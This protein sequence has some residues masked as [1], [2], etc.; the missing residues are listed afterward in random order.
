M[1]TQKIL[2][3]ATLVPGLLI[4]TPAFANLITV[5]DFSVAQAPVSDLTLD[6]VAVTVSNAVRTLSDNLLATIPPVH[7]A[8]EVSSGYLDINNGTGED[9]EVAVTWLLKPNLFPSNVATAAFYF[10][11]I[12][13]DNNPSYINFLLNGQNLASFSIPGRLMHADQSFA[14]NAIQ[15]AKIN[16]GGTLTLKINGD[17]GWDMAIDMFGFSFVTPPALIP[18]PEPGLLAMLGLGL[19]SLVFLRRKT[20]TLSKGV[21]LV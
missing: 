12:E 8:A 5:D 7:S 19:S 17:T 14:M 15:L 6:G 10:A 3:L 20:S 13:T 11:I 4:N 18:V 16:L 9:S 1:N 21:S 2:A